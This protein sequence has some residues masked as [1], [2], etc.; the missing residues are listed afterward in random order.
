MTG[1]GFFICINDKF[2][3]TGLG[4][5]GY[6]HTVKRIC[7]IFIHRSSFK[8]HAYRMHTVCAHCVGGCK[9][10][11]YLC[12]DDRRRIKTEEKAKVVASLPR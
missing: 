1:S 7:Y 12:I 3:V 5:M 2:E 10:R 9:Y 11:A 6:L 4:L 8:W